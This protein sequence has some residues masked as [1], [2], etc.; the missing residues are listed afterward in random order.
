MLFD[1]AHSGSRL[2]EQSSSLKA[3]ISY[4]SHRVGLYDRK[5][6]KLANS[7]TVQV[8]SSCLALALSEYEVARLRANALT[9][10]NSGAETPKRS[11][12]NDM[13]SKRAAQEVGTDASIQPV[14]TDDEQCDGPPSTTSSVSLARLRFTVTSIF[15]LG[16]AARYK[17][18]HFYTYLSRSMLT[19]TGRPIV[20]EGLDGC[21]RATLDF[22][23][24]FNPDAALLFDTV[25][26]SKDA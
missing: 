14:C 26:H 4:F 2:K 20:G 12:G 15:A 22:L 10:L 5:I 7:R 18:H 24:S 25:S 9:K 11:G 3:N 13:S 19:F 6:Q 1:V 8:I 21:S 23:V 16:E 17:T